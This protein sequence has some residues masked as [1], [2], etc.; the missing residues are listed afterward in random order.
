M[1]GVKT[2]KGETNGRYGIYQKIKRKKKLQNPKRLQSLQMFHKQQFQEVFNCLGN[3][4]DETRNR[5]LEAA[6]KLGYRPKCNRPQSDIQ[7][8][9]LIALISV[10]IINPHYNAILIK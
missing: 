2:L 8:P 7:P 4:K 10:D 5:V 3:I 9:N 6:K 1:S